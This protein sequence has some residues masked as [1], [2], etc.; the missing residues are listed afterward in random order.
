[1]QKLFYVDSETSGLNPV[2]QDILQLAFIIEIDGKIKENVNMQMQP[3][4]YDTVDQRALDVNKLTIEK[5]KTFITPQTAYKELIKILNR[6]IDKYNRLDKFMP[7]GYNVEF[8][9]N[10]LNSFFKK[11]GDNYFWSYFGYE[12][13]DPIPFLMLLQLK[14]KIKL[15]NFKLETACNYFEIPIEAHDAMEDIVATKRLVE[16][17]I[18]RYLK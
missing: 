1:M 7:C 16:L 13:L 10:F 15:K 6:Y 14:G 12:K 2:T 3:F 4:N 5:I 11:N 8:D 17:L 9:T 18:K